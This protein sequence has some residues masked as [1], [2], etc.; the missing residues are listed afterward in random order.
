MNAPAPAAFAFDH[1]AS[2]VPN[3]A[4]ALAWYQATLPDLQVLYQDESWAFI[5]AHGT[6]LALIRAGEH[7][8]HIAWR[9]AENELERL[10]QQLNQKIRPHRD[11]TRSF[12]IAA[13]G[14]QWIEFIS[15][16]PGNRYTD[17]A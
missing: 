17:P 8:G 5:E 9:V 6:K 4:N 3:V 15:Y 12:Y 11:G 16:P 2:E 14:D 10:A 13:P 1:V 7:P